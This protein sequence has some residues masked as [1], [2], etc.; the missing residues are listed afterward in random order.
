M[1]IVVPAIILFNP[2]TK[3]SIKMSNVAA[4]LHA[5]GVLCERYIIVIPGQTHAAEILPNMHVETAA[6][7]GKNVGYSISFLE[8]VQ[9][10]GIAAIVAVAFVLGLRIFAMMP[11]KAL[12]EAGSEDASTTG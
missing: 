5:A 6:L 8:T 12:I 10:L 3:N 2:G 4:V 11:T 1:G 7:Y 9:A